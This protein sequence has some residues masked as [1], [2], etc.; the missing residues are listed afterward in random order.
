MNEIA[1]TFAKLAGI[2]RKAQALL[3][4]QY[5]NHDADEALE[6]FE[7]H[8]TLRDRLRDLIPDLFGDLTARDLP[9]I[10]DQS[11]VGG[12]AYVE[13]HEV[14]RLVRDLDYLFE[15]RASSRPGETAESS[16]HPQRVF[17]SH[18][19]SPAWREVQSHIEKDI[20]LPTLELAQE[21]NRGRT[22]L[23]KLAEEASRCG[24]A[25]IV[26]TAKDEASVGPPRARE[27][28]IHEVGYFQG[29]L[30]LDRICVLHEE[31]TSIPSNIQ[32]LVYV[33][34]PKDL[35][36]ATFGELARELRAAFPS[37]R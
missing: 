20:G 10:H 27:N 18:G 34:F 35:V 17:V 31:G 26:M 6:L 24:F 12:K 25:V 13:N 11:Y 1:S 22:L 23:Q 8:L 15:V 4:R 37:H 28:V 19:R 30:G 3:D 9:P 32:G 5:R 36:R 16:D 2:R 29:K 33:P 21:A 14:E 7:G